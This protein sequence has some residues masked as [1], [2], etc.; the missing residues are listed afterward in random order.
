[1][2][3][4]RWLF[5]IR[6]APTLDHDVFGRLTFMRMR[7]PARSYWEGRAAMGPAGSPVQV[8]V[9]GGEDGPY[10][11]TTAFWRALLA[12]YRDLWPQLESTLGRAYREWIP[13]ARPDAGAGRFALESVSIPA[14]DPNAAEWDLGFACADDPEHSFT[15]LMRG[16]VPDS[17]V[18]IDG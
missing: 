16:W 17:Q 12:K 11:G 15:V 4:W 9:D 7:D 3:L 1:M 14:G 6:A 5:G 2:S 10:E 8:F 13:Q 18:R